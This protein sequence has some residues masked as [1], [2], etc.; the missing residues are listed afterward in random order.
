MESSSAVGDHVARADAGGGRLAVC[1][2]A[3]VIRV[4]KVVAGEVSSGS[5]EP[6]QE[7]RSESRRMYV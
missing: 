1:N 2:L 7:F 4:G 6:L 3:K 5:F